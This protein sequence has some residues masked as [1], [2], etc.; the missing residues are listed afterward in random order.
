MA[1]RLAKKKK[2]VKFY[3][4]KRHVIKF[5]LIFERKKEKGKR[6]HFEQIVDTVTKKKPNKS[7][8]MECS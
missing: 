7:T 6:R 4:H 8:Q 5:S 3:C 1:L 2:K